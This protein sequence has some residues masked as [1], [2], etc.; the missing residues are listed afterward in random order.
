MSSASKTTCIQLSPEDNVAVAVQAIQLGQRIEQLNLSCRQSIPSGHKV[1][2]NAIEKG[3]AIRKYNQIIGFAS[4]DIAPGDHVHTHN[5]SMGD[6]TRDYAFCVDA[7]PR[8]AVRPEGLTFDGYRRATGK[9]GT[10]N[11]LGLVTTVN[12]AGTVAN[13]V[14]EKVREEKLLADYPNIDGIVPLTHGSGC[15][16]AGQGEPFEMLGRTLQGYATH[17]N[18][19]GVLVLGLGCEV[20]QVAGFLKEYDLKKSDSFRAFTIQ[21][22]KG[23]RRTVADCLGTIREM[24]PQADAARREAIPVS[25]LVLALQCGGS[26]AWSGVSANPA[27]GYAADR[28][29]ANG[30]TVI[31]SETPEIYGAEHLLTRRAVSR[32][33]GEKLIERIQWWERY[34]RRNDMEMNNN[35][36][37]GNKEG[38]LTTILEK[39]LGAVAK[40]G[41]SDL[42]EVYLYAE[43]VRKR[44]LVFMDSPGFDPCSITGQVASGAN[45]IC[46]TTGRGSVYGYKPAP[47]IKLASNSTVYNRMQED[48]DINCGTIVDG[49][50]TVAEKGDE[51]FEYIVSVASGAASKSELLGFGGCEFVP[52]QTG[53]V[54]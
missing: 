50:S 6:F 28:L 38:G 2:V 45:I 52:W 22:S 54:M 51:I 53:A 10:R 34:T 30:G 16:M 36:S 26:D 19:A 39:S 42:A 44:G 32:E 3:Q 40:S 48:M 21:S 15:G 23:T 12:C 11:F 9:A 49:D 33:V 25:E 27:L 1:A 37:P 13:L 35:P 5:C 14:A 8:R 24:L 17:P 20:M 47:S 43:P 4:S 7:D 46:F 41:T 18:F 31:L 29:V